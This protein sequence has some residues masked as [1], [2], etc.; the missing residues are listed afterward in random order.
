MTGK[1]KRALQGSSSS[2]P[3]KKLLLA[4]QT[5]GRSTQ[6]GLQKLPDINTKQRNTAPRSKGKLEGV[7]KPNT[8]LINR[9]DKSP[10]H[11]AD[12]MLFFGVFAC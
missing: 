2:Q 10:P 4:V 9:G 1:K 8:S 11:S 6:A 3:T 12:G 5:E 7:S